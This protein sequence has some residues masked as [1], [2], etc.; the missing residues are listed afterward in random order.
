MVKDFIE[1][2][3]SALK[4]GN[5]ISNEIQKELLYPLNFDYI[6]LVKSKNVLSK[7]EFKKVNRLYKKESNMEEL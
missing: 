2:P 5:P 4:Y 3:K 1:N 6:V 7:E